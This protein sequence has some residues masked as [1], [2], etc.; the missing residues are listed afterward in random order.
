MLALH[1]VAVGAPISAKSTHG[2]AQPIW[3]TAMLLALMLAMPLLSQAQSNYVYVNNQSAAN[4]IVAYSVSPA[5]VLTSVPGSPFA[6]GG[7][8]KNV[9][10]YG[11]DRIIVTQ[12]NN[13]LYVANQGDM[14]ISGFSINPATG[15]LSLV[16]G[17]P[18]PS[19]LSLD[20]CQGIS[21]AATPDA[22]FLMASSNGQ[23]QTFS[24]TANG[25]LALAGTTANCCTPN[26][27]IKISP[28][29]QFLAI[30]NEDSVSTFTLNSLTGALTPVLGS[31]F[32]KT[33]TGL[34][35]G[36]D[37]NGCSNNR[38]YG[39]EATGTPALADAWTVDAA[40]ALFPIAGSPFQSTGADSNVVLATPNNALLFESNQLNNG[41]TSFAIN[42]D[43]SLTLLGKFGGVGTVHA[44]VGMAT[45]SSGTFLYVADDN[46][47]MALYRINGNG[48]LT[49][50]KDQGIN[51]PAEIQGV[52]AY[53]PRSCASADLAVAMTASPATVAANNTVTYSI[54]I[55]NNGP[56]A[57][58]FSLADTLPSTLSFVSCTA[59]GGGVCLGTLGNRLVSFPSMASGSSATVTLV[60]RVSSTVTNGTTITNTASLNNSSAVD[61]NTAN[62]SA[63]S[64]ITGTQPAATTLTV[65][66][67]S[68]SFGGSAVLSATLRKKSDNSPAV[69]ETINFF[70][71]RAS[72]G[73]ALTDAN[74]VAT[75]PAS[76][77]TLTPGTYSGAIIAT[78]TGDANFATSSGSAALTVTKAVLT[79]TAN[80]A[81]RTY[82]DPN[83]TFTY[84]ISGFV[85]GD[86][87]SVVSGS[88]SCTST[89]TASSPVGTY[90]IVCTQGTLAAANYTFAFVPGNLTVTQA[91]LTVTVNNASRSYGTANPTFT[92]TITGI[93][94]GDNIT[95]TYSTTATAASPVGTYPITATLV[96][97]AGA[98]ANYSVTTTNGALTITTAT[99]TAVASSS[100]RLYGDPDPAFTGTLT[101]VQLGDN[102]TASYSSV[103][104]AAS[105]VGSYPITPVL[106]DPGNKLGNYSVTLTNGVLTVTPSPLAVVAANATRAYGAPNPV[107]TGTITGIKN[108][109]NITATYASPAIATSSPG[110]YPIIPTLVDPASKLA[111]YSVTST[112]GT[113]TVSASVLTVTAANAS[114]LYGDPNPAFTGTITG[115]QNGD[116]ITA[117]YASVADPTSPV[118]TYTIVP[119]LVD[120]NGKLVNYT[121]VINNGTLTVNAAPLTVTAAN[122]SRA[123]G[124]ANPAFSGTI[125]GIKNGDNITATYA[126]AATA[127]SNAGTYAII[128]TLV[129]PT[130]KLGNYTV[131]INNGTLTVTAVPL[132]VTAANASRLYGD[133]N[134]AFSGTITG[135]LN[136]DNI[137]ATFSSV[138]IPAS[139][140]GT[141][142]IVPTLVDPTGKLGN[143][144]VTSN[145]GILTI[146]V[147]PL[148]VSAANATRAF[149]DP[150]PV[151]TGTISGLKNG[152]NISA[153][154]STTATAASPAGTYPIVPALVDPTLKLGNY[155]V[156]SNNG[157]LTV[158]SA[159]L[160]VTAANASRF[161]GDP[162]PVFS[163]TITGLKNGDTI[164]ATY[165]STANAT[166][167][168]GTYAIVPTLVDPGNQAVNY[169]VVINNGVLTVNPAPL[170]AAAANATRAYGSANPVFSG[171]LTGLKNGDAITATYTSA[172]DATSNVGTYPITPVLSD[173]TNK[174]SNYAVTLTNGTLTVTSVPLTVTAANASR[175]FG[176]SNPTFTGTITGILNGDNITATYASVADAT[177]PAGTYPIVPT[178]ADPTGKLGNYSV[179]STNGTLTVTSAVLTVTAANASRFYGD[180]NPAFTGT[181][182]GLKNGDNITATYASVADAASAPGTFPI[183]P[184][185][186]DPNSKLGNYTVVVNNGILTVNA[187]P[188]TVTAA[189]ANRF[190]GDPNPAFTGTTTGLKNGDNITAVYSSVA[191]P[192]S[193]VG[194]YA[195]VPALAD[196]NSKLGNYAVT[197]N[198][199]TLTVNPAPL[200]VTAANASRV[201]GDPNP[202][203]T[204]TLIGLKNGDNITAT[205]SSAADPTS[206]VGNYPIVPALADPNGRLSNYVVTSNNGTLTV[207][208]APLL[209]TADDASRSVGQPNP[210]F[211]GTIA[212]VKNGD[213]ITATFDSPATV[214]SPEGTY[215][216][217]PTLADPTGK[218]SNYAVTITNGTLTLTP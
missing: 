212:G 126:S 139:P 105:P 6:T 82:G 110:S 13:L 2:T 53:P 39:G 145:N 63:S 91:P 215:P 109:D 158:T 165:A 172:T 12:V 23:I 205:F 44:P 122:A 125:T 83:P 163:G 142:A 50:I 34:V 213:N 76:L 42:T 128:P 183:V 150:N 206:P 35:T 108:G 114:R 40:G 85:N 157:T 74:G 52:A 121:V 123:Y 199:G 112:N 55:T 166:S 214:D 137:T 152:D 21:I 43:G 194:F 66:P 62:N 29:G 89:A 161:Y 103:A 72:V 92:G 24:I 191:D 36:L 162:N 30:A 61:P 56:S 31:P 156:T 154:Y 106:S 46:F 148:T 75:L 86:T 217:I 15:A 169:T 54:T 136:G 200:V 113:L 11:L 132:T 184:T 159:V 69:G 101:G 192:T 94:N 26:A 71:N 119:T 207:S 124:S 195:I 175:A 88:P 96:D 173:P 160:T 27:G 153:T 155:A 197:I 49:S 201:Y 111:N 60:A 204:G 80:N 203:F 140:V 57:A 177:S 38:L 37:F 22:H 28:N 7:A 198:N 180:P 115:L 73:S 20:A 48:S 90:P 64:N 87:I 118:G 95:A 164:S 202:A 196:P 190:F 179:T 5:G 210:P 120:P 216:I 193:P 100:S 77:G 93:K 138:A 211:T 151:F 102:I 188:L 25:S 107:F 143:Y 14:T 65:S 99:L 127:T 104:T 79:V 133:P 1:R 4:S 170:T 67:A 70:L 98:L 146:T 131:T 129:D 18:F 186:V 135:L 19:G 78:F 178:L 116:N 16:A 58:A 68:G 97:P 8:G 117:T 141:Y 33:G 174:L 32:P 47:G 185:L 167:A 9:V 134:P 81:S 171:T 182:T 84:A 10:C 3:L 187:A 209:V 176:D 41:I 189:N 144:T 218:L 149:G 168:P 59:T 45:D 181:I 208:P 51:L 147:A 130:S 17:S